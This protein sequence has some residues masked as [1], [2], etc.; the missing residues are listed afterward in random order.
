[1]VV[2]K[3]GVCEEYCCSQCLEP[4]G[5][6]KNIEH[7]CIEEKV[8]TATYIKNSTR[9]VTSLGSQIHGFPHMGVAHIGP[10]I[11]TSDVKI[12]PISADA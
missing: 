4:L 2:I 3:C 6:D 11:N 7:E 8:Q 10:V 5:P 1:M 12:V 9:V